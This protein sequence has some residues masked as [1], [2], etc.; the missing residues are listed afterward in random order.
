MNITQY[1][2]D[3][4]ARL[5]DDPV[6]I[7]GYHSDS[8]IRVF[9]NNSRR[10]INQEL[11]V[12][13]NQ[14]FIFPELNIDE[15]ALDTDYV[16]YLNAFDNR[17]NGREVTPSKK[18]LVESQKNL[19]WATTEFN[20]NL[21]YINERRRVFTL[22]NLPTS[23]DVEPTYNIKT[24]SR[25]GKTIV[26]DG[27]STGV[28]SD[29]TK[30]N[31]VKGYI[32]AITSAGVTEY[33]RVSKIEPNI[34]NTEYT[35]Y[36][37]SFDL[38]GTLKNGITVSGTIGVTNNSSAVT[39]NGTKFL[40]DCA[41]GDK[42]VIAGATYTILTVTS[43]TAMTL[44]VVYAG[45]T[46]PVLTATID[47]RPVFV[48]NDTIKFATIIVNYISNPKEMVMYNEDDQMPM[49]AQELVTILSCVEAGMRESRQDVANTNY[50]EYTKELERRRTK[51]NIDSSI[52]YNQTLNGRP[53]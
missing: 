30:W 13:E 52:Q 23:S 37:S 20:T 36:I 12:Y 16:S 39:G 1:I 21:G 22:S 38:K 2:R 49:E 17:I 48:D 47:N 7:D 32:K 4:R 8:Q 33:M 43:N 25:S 53:Y 50:A 34:D 11:S 24:F 51:L 31:S 14:M 40:F 5:D 41:T 44:S 10:K 26:V 19:Y 28:L 6:G 35:L 18:S 3:I 45:T 9:I 15:Y 29:I 42:I 27:V 46:A